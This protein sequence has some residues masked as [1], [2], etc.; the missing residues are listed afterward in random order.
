[1]TQTGR[2]ALK[3]IAENEKVSSASVYENGRKDRE[4]TFWKSIN[5]DEFI[6][7]S[8]IWLVSALLVAIVLVFLTL[9]E[10]S[11]NLF[12]DVMNRTDT[13][14]L[15]FSLVLS[16][17]LEQMWNHKNSKMH[18]VT[19]ACEVL[20]MGIGLGWYLIC[21]IHEIQLADPEFSGYVNPVFTERFWV[22]TVYVILSVCC[23]FLGFLSR[24]S[25]E[26]E[27]R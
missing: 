21:S 17:T 20:L 25:I 8:L 10:K 3:L 7:L 5:W 24:V 26:R 22:H 16:A 1:M 19:L 2:E 27:E 6:H 15:M 13:L 14:S 11:T 23:V 12:H 4:N 18:Q 9:E